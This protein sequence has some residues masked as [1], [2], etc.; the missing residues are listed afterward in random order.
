MQRCI[1]TLKLKLFLQ[2]CF[3]KS[4]KELPILLYPPFIYSPKLKLSKCNERRILRWRNYRGKTYTYYRYELIGE[5]NRYNLISTFV[6]KMLIVLYLV[7][8]FAIFSCTLTKQWS[9]YSHTCAYS[10]LNIYQ[11]FFLWHNC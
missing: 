1:H 2:K 9:E 5:C 3:K 7:Y 8:T 4:R 6:L 11:L 10:W